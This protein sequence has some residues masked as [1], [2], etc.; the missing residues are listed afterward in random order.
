VPFA[1]SALVD[2]EGQVAARCTSHC[3]TREQDDIRILTKGRMLA[4]VRWARHSQRIAGT[5][6]RIRDR[7]YAFYADF[8]E[9]DTTQR[10]C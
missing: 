5:M 8:L 1:R 10:K 4:R 7:N 2:G 9:L 3:V 6:N